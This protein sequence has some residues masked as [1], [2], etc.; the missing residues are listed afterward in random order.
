M[1]NSTPNFYAI[2]PAHVRYCKNLE[3]SAKLLYGE[4]TALA[5]QCGYCFASNSYFAELYGVD[6]RT[7]RRWLESLKKLN[8]IKIETDKSS[9]HWQRKI[10]ISQE[11]QN[12][13]MGG[14]N[15]HTP[16]TKVSAPPDK[17]APNN[18]TYNN[19]S[20]KGVK[21]MS[22]VQAPDD[23]PA[24]PP[25]NI[26]KE[27]QE[28]AQEIFKRVQEIHPKAKL[29]NFASWAKT[30][31]LIN[32]RDNRSWDEI[33]VMLK[34]A[35]EHDFW[36]KQIQS[37]EALRRHWDKMA[38]QMSPFENKAA[39]AKKNRQTAQDIKL[40]L[41]DSKLLW[42]GDD[43]VANK[44]NGESIMLDLNSDTFEQILCKW[45]GLERA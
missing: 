45:F 14:Q 33:R 24:L 37:P 11:I 18:T 34:W 35:Y 41:S 43:Y 36:Y 42:I 2:I 32:K 26:S 5:N 27:S 30:L 40:H 39:V 20:N 7:V 15:C 1:S 21:I 12:I 6:E 31:E 16:R 9:V 4:I 28:I 8:F 22:Q 23:V 17:N 29:P 44:K 25:S 13:F 19:T 38:I 3:P 10:W